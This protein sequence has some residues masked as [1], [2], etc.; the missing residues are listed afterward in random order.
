[1]RMI[2]KRNFLVVKPEITSVKSQYL[3]QKLFIWNDVGM[4]WL[5]A[6]KSGLLNLEFA[7][8]VIEEGGFGEHAKEASVLDNG[9]GPDL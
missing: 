3:L 4:G 6:L 5:E 8:V 9:E 7:A 2:D 1:M